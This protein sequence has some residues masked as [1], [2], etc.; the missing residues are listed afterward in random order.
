MCAHQT[1][2]VSNKRQ[3]YI[4]EWWDSVYSSSK[5]STNYSIDKIWQNS[6]IVNGAIKF[7]DDEWKSAKDVSPQWL[8]Y[9]TVYNFMSEEVP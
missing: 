2:L 3:K 6:Y 8:L 1:G 9:R 4:R 7:I 5:N